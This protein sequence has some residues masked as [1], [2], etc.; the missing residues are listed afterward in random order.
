[1]RIT[2]ITKNIFQ[3]NYATQKELAKAFC[4]F[5]EYYESPEFAGKIFTLA[6]YRK[7]YSQRY[8]GWTYYTDWGGFNIPDY[9]FEPFKAGSFDPLTRA[10]KDLLN[11][12]RQRNGKFY[13]IGTF[14]K[15]PDSLDH[16]ICHALF[17]LDYVYRNTVLNKLCVSALDQP[18]RFK[19]LNDWLVEDKGYSDGFVLDEM[20]AYL[21]CNALDLY[22]DHDIDVPVVYNEL[23]SI[24][25]KFFNKYGIDERE[26]GTG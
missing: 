21:A 19:A 4:R 13:V 14:G 15:N 6:E 5:Q 24:R 8:G 9:V 25:K 11:A 20:Q 12:F 17:Y 3:V 22:Y 23:E 1:M 18:E 16:E 2:K 7:W 26:L 10:E